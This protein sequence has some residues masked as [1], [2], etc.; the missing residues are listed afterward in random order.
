MSL[1]RSSRWHLLPCCIAAELPQLARAKER[2]QAARLRLGQRHEQP[3][4]SHPSA[5]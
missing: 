4:V 5:A 2:H 1:E 3:P